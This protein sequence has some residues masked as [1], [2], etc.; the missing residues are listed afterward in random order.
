MPLG[1]PRSVQGRKDRHCPF[2]EI[3]YFLL[4]NEPAAQRLD[5]RL[6]GRLPRQKAE[7]PSDLA[8]PQTHLDQSLSFLGL[9]FLE[10]QT[11]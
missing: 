4:G 7:P 5:A 1:Q 3:L 6:C 8:L 10:K 2:A 9:S 11:F